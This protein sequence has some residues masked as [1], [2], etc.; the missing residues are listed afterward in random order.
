MWATFV[1]WDKVADRAS[2]RMGSSSS[3]SA[4]GDSDS[5]NGNGNKDVK[6]QVLYYDENAER[7][8]MYAIG[9]FLLVLILT[10][11]LIIAILN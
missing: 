10:I 1:P 2:N 5:K 8:A 4:T 11:I 7:K 3:S 6:T 9:G